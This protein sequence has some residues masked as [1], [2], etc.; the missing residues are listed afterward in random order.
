[1]QEEIDGLII[2]SQCWKRSGVMKCG[3]GL[4]IQVF[5]ELRSACGGLLGC[6]RCAHVSMYLYHYFSHCVY[7]PIR[8]SLNAFAA[9]ERGAHQDC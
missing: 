9:Y 8:Q 3:G 5:V 7:L 2:H 6:W 4:S 1:M